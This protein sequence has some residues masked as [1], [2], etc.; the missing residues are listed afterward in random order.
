M[1]KLQKRT[2]E[3]KF[4]PT[5]CKTIFERKAVS[6]FQ[7]AVSASRNAVL[8]FSFFVSVLG[9]KERTFSILQKGR[10]GA[11]FAALFLGIALL[12]ASCGKKEAR[13]EKFT[14]DGRVQGTYYHIVYY[15]FD[16]SEAKKRNLTGSEQIRKGLDSVFKAIDNTLSLWNPNS[17]LSKVNAGTEVALN[18][19]F[20]ENFQASQRFS[21]MTDGAFDI[22]VAPLVKAYGFANEGRKKLSESQIDSL[23]QYVGWQKVRL[24]GVRLVKDYP[25]T[26]FDFN[27]IAQGYTTDKVSGFFIANGIK[28]FIVDVGGEVYAG[29]RKP[30]GQM[31][32]VAIEEPSDSLEAPREYNSFLKLENQSVVTSGNY[33]KYIIEDGIK[34]SHTINPKTG[35]P[36]RH[37]LLSVSV[38]AKT[39]LEAD[40]IATAFMVMGMEKA[41]E[42]IAKNPQYS[43]L[44]IYCDSEGRLQTKVSEGLK[45]SLETLE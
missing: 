41:E 7:K 30:D 24:E 44:F 14:L 36:A 35:R 1:Q 43:A 29:E 10:A 21:E 34:Y 31:W 13:L 12:F 37:N 3:T 20:I 33:R 18:E 38:V 16:D 39:A 15:H 19:I 22:T 5:D 40:A 45:G 2:I 32:R 28:S 17:V 27:A 9:N 25:Q 8:I 4:E 42:F 23:M 6:V 11:R 26:Q